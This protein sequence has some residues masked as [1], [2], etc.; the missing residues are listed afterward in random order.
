[1][2]T[3]SS[4]IGDLLRNPIGSDLI[5]RLVQYAGLNDGLLRNPLV[6]LVPLSSLQRLPGGLLDEALLDDLLALCNQCEGEEPARGDEAHTWWK[7][8][9]IYQIYPRSFCDSNGDGVGD[10]P[11]VIEKLPY[12]AELGV[13]ALWLSPV[14]DS[15][16]DDNGYDVRDYRKIMAEF[17]AMEDMDRLIAGAHALGIRVVLD[18]VLNHTSDEHEWYRRALAGEAPYSDYYIFRGG[19]GAAPPN[20][21]RSFF[22]GSAWRYEPARQAW[23]LHLFSPKQMDLNW[24]NPAV[25]ADVCELVRFWRARGVD[26][27]RLD[28]INLISKTSLRD[29]S[30]TLGGLLGTTGIEHYFYGDRLH[31]YLRELRA[32]GLGNAFAVGETPGTGAEMNK[33][34]AAP[35]R[36]ELDLVFCF[37]HLDELGK[38]RFDDYRYD[39]NHLKR[40]LL[41]YQGAYAD[42]AWP[43]IFLENHDNPRMVSKVEPSLAHRTVLAK[44]LALLQLTA[45][46]TVFLFQGQELGAAN[47]AFQDISELRDVESLNRYAELCAGGMDEADAFI[48]VLTGTRDHARV[49]MAW[50]GTANGGF[51]TGTPW[52]R[53]NDPPACN[54]AAQQCDPDSVLSFYK[55][56]IGLRRAIPALIYGRFVPVKPRRRDVFCYL[57][58]DGTATYYVEANLTDRSQRRPLGISGMERLVCN[59]AG[60]DAR[61]RP[62][63]AALY[64][65]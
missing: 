53:P 5:G 14:Y 50:D 1:M 28:V 42:V 40:C 19:R 10:L 47:A 17:G 62:Y 43:S 64:R 45:R 24:E 51:T 18:M 34:L 16:N 7:E 55:L 11:G 21:W 26:G 27:F 3:R 39:L 32:E 31:E 57:R 44:L 8:A 60:V 4:R 54:A 37:D 63:E 29:G 65:C 52:I 38:S 12:L 15:P 6:R 48:A 9:V 35:S 23:A 49:P 56:L 30:E 20:N 22:S 46:G 25:R 61:L 59:Y 36:H 41:A 58:T 13:T 2:L 33:L